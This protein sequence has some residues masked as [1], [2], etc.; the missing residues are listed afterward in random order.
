MYINQTSEPVVPSWEWIPYDIFIPVWQIPSIHMWHG[1]LKTWPL[2]TLNPFNLLRLIHTYV[3]WLIQKGF[4]CFWDCTGVEFST[5]TRPW[6][7]RLI[8]TYV[9]WLM[10]LRGVFTGVDFSAVTGS[11]RK[12]LIPAPQACP[13]VIT[14]T[15]TYI[16]IYI[17]MCVRVYIYI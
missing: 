17:Y 11:Q 14:E 8:L 9:T 6:P 12:R 3:K 16:Y 2:Q 5:V 7:L 4:F 10:F 13:C 15:Y 1:S